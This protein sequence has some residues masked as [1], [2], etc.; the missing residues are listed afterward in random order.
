MDNI[1]G[2]DE[3]GEKGDE[4]KIDKQIVLDHIYLLAYSIREREGQK[5][6]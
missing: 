3:G 4:S 1:R 5:A 6:I 2:D